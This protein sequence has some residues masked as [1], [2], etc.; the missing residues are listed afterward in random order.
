MSFAGFAQILG[1]LKQRNFRIFMT[2]HLLSQISMWMTRIV[3]GW[4]T[5]ELTSRPPGSA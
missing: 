3:A 5:W 4:Q 1:A 2:G